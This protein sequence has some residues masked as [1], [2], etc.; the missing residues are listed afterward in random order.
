[1]A[2][3]LTLNLLFIA[4]VLVALRIKPSRPSIPWV[5]TLI[6]LLVLTAIFDSLII[7]AGIVAYDSSKL[8]G[9]YIGSAPIE[10]FFYAVL[11]IILIPAIWH[12]LGGTYVK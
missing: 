6:A 4:V 5:V 1:M 12:K 9:I 8:L 3:Y 10:D 11:A 2:T 7:N